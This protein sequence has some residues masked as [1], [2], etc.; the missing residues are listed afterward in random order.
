MPQSESAEFIGTAHRL[1]GT[2]LS[3]PLDMLVSFVEKPGEPLALSFECL[4]LD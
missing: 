4:D 3:I 2:K 1:L